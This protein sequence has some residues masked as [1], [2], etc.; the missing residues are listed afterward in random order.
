MRFVSAAARPV[1]ESRQTESKAGRDLAVN[2]SLHGGESGT[3]PT[4]GFGGQTDP[5]ACYRSVSLRGVGAW[6]GGSGRDSV[7]DSGRARSV[8]RYRPRDGRAADR[9]GWRRWSRGAAANANWGLA[10]PREGV[11][12]GLAASAQKNRIGSQDQGWQGLI[13]DSDAVLSP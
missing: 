13:S 7:D 2:L 1:D 11:R 5:S 12:G 4:R 9:G 6:T 8:A 10:H 3:S